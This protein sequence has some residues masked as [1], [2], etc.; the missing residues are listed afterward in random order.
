MILS[1]R[2]LV[3]Y[4]VER[5]LVAPET[6]VD[7]DYSAREMSSR[8]RNFRVLRGALPGLFV[9]QPADWE[10]FSIETLRREATCYLLARDDPDFAALAELMPRFV[11]FDPPHF[12]LTVELLPAA[13]TL[14]DHLG[15]GDGVPQRVAERLGTLLGGYHRHAGSRARDAARDSAFPRGIPWILNV[16]HHNPAVVGP[17]SAGNRALVEMLG[18]YPAFGPAIDAVR[19]GWRRDAL[20][21][22]DLKWEN[23]L[24][25]A[26]AGPGAPPELRI[27][28]W[29]LADFGDA[30]WDVGSVFQ[31]YLSSWLL[32]IPATAGAGTAR[33]GELAALPIER[34]QPA[35]HAFWR[36]YAGTLGLDAAAAAERLRRS[37]LFAAARLI[38][39]AWEYT[40]NTEHVPP[41][42]LYLMQV[43]MNVLTRPDDAV[44]H[45]LGFEEGLAA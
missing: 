5:G 43:A 38:Q 32:S 20:V 42:V 39:T 28:D 29:E 24:V 18:R 33:L 41:N 45:L 25:V 19:D 36:A 26:P 23:C 1:S 9:K 7:G 17:V 22:G 3:H 8:N 30:C 21:H 12:V 16:M 13:E 4:L 34:M 6:V 15:R 35:I 10:P 40:A 11:D 2:T 37:I 44:R 14:G 31:A 27:V